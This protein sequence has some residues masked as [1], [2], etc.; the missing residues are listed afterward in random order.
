ME[1]LIVVIIDFITHLPHSSNRNN[2]ILG[3]TDKFSKTS[4]FISRKSTWTA[5]EW[6][7][8]VFNIVFA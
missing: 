6:A 4:Y 3:I 2:T 1:P 5:I 7:N 8:T